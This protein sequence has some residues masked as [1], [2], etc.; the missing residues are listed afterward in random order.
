MIDV[1]TKPQ[2]LG[3]GL[4]DLAT[5][6][7]QQDQKL[8]AGEGGCY[9]RHHV[10]VPRSEMQQPVRGVGYEARRHRL[11]KRGRVKLP[12]WQLNADRLH[13]GL[14]EGHFPSP[15]ESVNRSEERRVGKECRSRWSPY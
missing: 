9:G 4:D 6:L 8:V 14:F 15:F 13:H 12:P 5:F 2:T 7:D 1:E 10:I 3:C 11:E